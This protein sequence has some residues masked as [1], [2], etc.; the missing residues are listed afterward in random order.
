MAVPTWDKYLVPCLQVLSD[1]QVRQR[2]DVAIEAAD[3]MGISEMD[4]QELVQ[5]GE[6]RFLNRAHWAITHL[7][8]AAAVSSP[9]RGQWQITD[10]GRRLLAQHPAG[11][12]E[13][14]LRRAGGEKYSDFVQP[15]PSLTQP[16]PV[17]E[18]EIS[19]LTPLEQ[20]EAG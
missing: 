15:S 10:E 3:I 14:D 8:K 7:S 5:S 6:P 16:L 1:G 17:P 4:R 13:G 11:L 2:R 19:A 20:V 9:S 12:S 18:E